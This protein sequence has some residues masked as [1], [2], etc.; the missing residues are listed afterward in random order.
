MVDLCEYC[1]RSPE[2]VIREIVTGFSAF[3]VMRPTSA[4]L[5]E[6]RAYTFGAESADRETP[7]LNAIRSLHHL[8]L[9]TKKRDDYSKSCR[10]NDDQPLGVGRPCI[11]A[12]SVF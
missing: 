2:V 12:V 6:V 1:P 8:V 5:Y 9:R 3:K 7:V 11:Y 10:D 4:P